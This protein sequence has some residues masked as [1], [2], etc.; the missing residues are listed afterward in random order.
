MSLAPRMTLA[1]CIALLMAL[2][3]L[4]EIVPTSQLQAVAPLSSVQK[5]ALPP[6][7]LVRAAQDDEIRTLQGEPD[8]FAMPEKLSITPEDA[9]TWEELPDQRS[10]LWRLRIES[11]G[12][13]SLNLGFDRFRL[14]EGARLV[15]HP[16]NGTE[17]AREF[18]AHDNRSHGQL[19]TPVILSDGLVIELTIPTVSRHDYEL[20]LIQVGKGY[21]SFGDVESDKSGACNNDVVCPE[22][23]P[24]RAEINSVGVFTVNGV[25]KCSG[26]MINN[27]AGDETP[28]FLTANHCNINEISDASVVVYWNYQ[29]PECGQ[30]GGGSLEDFQSGV[31]YRASYQPTDFCLV[32]LEE[33]PDP[34]WQLTFSGWDR[35]DLE[36]SNAVCIHHPSTDEKAISFEDDPTFITSYLS[37][38]SPGD[39]THLRL[40]D[41]DD[42]TTEGGSSGSPLYNADHHIVGQLHGGYASCNNDLSDWYGRFHVSWEGGGTSN[43]RLRDWLDPDGLEPWTLDLYDPHSIRISVSPENGLDSQGLVGGPFSPDSRQYTITN[44]SDSN[45]F[46]QVNNRDSWIELSHEG[47]LLEP[48]ATATVTVSI[49]AG[50]AGLPSGEYHGEVEFLNLTTG[51]GDTVRPVQLQIGITTA[52]YSWSMDSDPGWD[53]E[54]QW[55]FGVPLGGGGSQGNPD[56]TEGFD[57]PNV[58]GY[59]LAGDYP[60][61]LPE[62]SLTTEAINCQQLVGVKLRFR[63]WLNVELWPYDFASIRVSTDGVDWTTIWE[64][65]GAIADDSWQGVQYDLSEVADGQPEVYVRWVMGTTNAFGRYSGWNIDNVEI[66]GVEQVPVGVPETPVARARLH[67]AAPNPFNPRTEVSFTMARSGPVKLAI[68]DARGRLVRMLSDDVFETGD[69]AVSW[70]GTDDRGRRLGSGVYFVQLVAGDVVDTRKVLMVK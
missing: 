40:V 50:A 54:G 63:R 44:S 21:R 2:P 59:N 35:R 38:T 39:G 46:Y 32:E 28:Y 11:P 43:S 67:G 70:D 3:A 30:Q 61:N 29:S 24:W 42:G 13:L 36:T 34:A 8:R 20:H 66:R 17:L 19:W 56:P 5:I 18:T 37:N 41:W 48:G 55:E 1:A 57:G 60:D 64:N 27:T 12:A 69:H 52:A 4:A 6:V 62:Q 49:H 25:W 9:G 10:M 14:P 15:V 45:I 33:D 23:D 16:A 58:M 65:T 51:Q 47:G 7:D 68:H 53:R 26:A 31:I 22:G